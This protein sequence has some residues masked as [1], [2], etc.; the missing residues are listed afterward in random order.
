[1]NKNCIV[2]VLLVLC[3][4]NCYSMQGTLAELNKASEEFCQRSQELNRKTQE[5]AQKKKESVNSCFILV[6][7]VC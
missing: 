6:P 3:R 4:I 1:M 5:E 2:F 7:S